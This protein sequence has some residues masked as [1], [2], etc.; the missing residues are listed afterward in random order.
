MIIDLITLENYLAV[1]IQN[2]QCWDFPGCLVV[3]KPPANAQDTGLNPG[4]G[5]LH[6]WW[7]TNP[8]HHKLY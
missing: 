3:K 4:L 8:V 2:K 1:F 7:T 5:R 6:T